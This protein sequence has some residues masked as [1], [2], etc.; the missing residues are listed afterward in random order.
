MPGSS[1]IAEQS[2]PPSLKTNFAQSEN[3]PRHPSGSFRRLHLLGLVIYLLCAN[4]LGAYEVQLMRNL[5]ADTVLTTFNLF[6][7]KVVISSSTLI[8]LATLIVLFVAL[9]RLRLLPRSIRRS[10]D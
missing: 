8:F 7:G 2:T 3:A 10:R 6:G 9:A 1:K 5:H 4:F